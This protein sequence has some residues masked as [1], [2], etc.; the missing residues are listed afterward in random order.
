MTNADMVAE[1][2]RLT[3]KTIKKFSSRAAGERQLAALKP[4][5]IT[6]RAHVGV[7]VQ[8][9]GE[10]SSV[11]KAFAALCLPMRRCIKFRIALK[12]SGAERFVFENTTYQFRVAS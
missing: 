5:P 10:F 9:H 11:P 12:A 1:Y 3:G 7:I 2:N 4:K 6:T 8:G